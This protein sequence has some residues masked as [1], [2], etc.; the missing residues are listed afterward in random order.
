MALNKRFVCNIDFS[1]MLFTVI[2]VV[3]G[4][5]MIYSATRYSYN[6]TIENQFFYLNKQ[7][8]AAILGFVVLLLVSRIDYYCFAKHSKLI[9][10]LS[11]VFLLSVFVL[12]TRTKGAINWIK[13][14]PVAIQPSEFAKYGFVILLA[15]ELTT[16]NKINSLKDF[17]IPFI[18][19]II[20]TGIVV[21]QND[22]GSALVFP[23][24]LLIMLFVA[25]A[26]E[27]IFASILGLILFVITPITYY[28]FLSPYQ[29]NRIL[30]FLDPYSDPTGSGYNVLQSLITIGSGRIFGKGYG[31]S[32]QAR[33][34]F[35]PAHHTDFIFSIIAEEFGFIGAIFVLIILFVIVRRGI[36][37]SRYANDK[38]GSFVAIGIFSIFL[39]HITVNIGMTMNLSPCTGIPLP[40]FSAGGSS[41]IAS[42]LGIGIL[43]SIYIRRKK[44]N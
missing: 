14:G 4:C 31:N 42:L 38:F 23:V 25:E 1:L 43:E 3:A 20:P 19:M 9:Y 6:L 11:I 18:I 26:N 28:F 36:I 39:T 16:K 13:I 27:K 44:F 37:I 2:A 33:L 34:N 15:Q 29:Q 41:L 40:F 22:L 35:L 32:T 10:F 5:I 21:L 17:I 12:G 30:V 8:I 24:V 7:I